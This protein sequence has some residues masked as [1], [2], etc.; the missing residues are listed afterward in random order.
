MRGITG[1]VKVFEARSQQRHVANKSQFFAC[2][3]RFAMAESH[4]PH[5]LMVLEEGVAHKVSVSK[6]LCDKIG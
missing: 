1:H 2:N 6:V 4:A 3:Q 5:C